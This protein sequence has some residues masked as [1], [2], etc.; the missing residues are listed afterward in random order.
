MERRTYLLTVGTAGVVATAGCLTDIAKS[1][2]SDVV[3]SEP[4]GKL[5]DP[6]DLPYPGY[7]QSIP[8]FELPD[9]INDVVID[10][11]SLDRTTVMTGFF[12]SCPAECGILMNHL[13][14][15]QNQTIEREWTD[16]VVF[17]P[18][19]FDPERDDAE[20]LRENADMVGADLDAGNWH[21]LRP[22]DRDEAK[23]IVS[24]QLGLAFERV[25]DSQRVVGYDFN[26][27]VLTWLVNPDG[28]VERVYRGEVL[29]RERVLS[30]MET[31][32]G[33]YNTQDATAE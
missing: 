14:G 26:H 32:I 20:H 2:P 30:D 18:I 23:A 19:T 11:G 21:Y 22:A 5:A 17:L 31:V 16:D 29:D 13:A 24:D 15:I 33:E 3:L 10:T 1:E 9:P 28:V 8:Q 27:A 4:E 12:A 7:G 25:T 6:S